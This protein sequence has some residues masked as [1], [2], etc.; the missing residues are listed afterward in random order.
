MLSRWLDR[1]KKSRDALKEY[2]AVSIKANALHDAWSNMLTEEKCIQILQAGSAD[3]LTE[4]YN[5]FLEGLT[6]VGVGKILC[7]Q[8][9]NFTTSG[10]IYFLQIEYTTLGIK[11]VFYEQYHALKFEYDKAWTEKEVLSKKLNR[12]FSWLTANPHIRFRW[13]DR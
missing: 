7:I 3:E 1:I 4:L 11:D 6:K 2:S 12:Y 13:L 9:K 10:D 5:E 8:D